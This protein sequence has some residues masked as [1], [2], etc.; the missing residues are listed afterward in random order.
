MRAFTL[1]SLG[2]PPSVRDLPAPTPGDDQVLVRVHASSV[3]PADAAVVAGRLSGMAEHVFPV[4]IGRDFAGTVEQVG[5]AVTRYTGGEYVYG[6]LPLTN[7]A[8]HD[9]AWAELIVTPEDNFI[10]PAPWS[11]DLAAAGAS[12]LAAITA[13]ALVDALELVE[14][15]TVLVVGATGGVGSF[16][17]QLAVHAGATVIAP[18]LAEDSDYLRGLGVHE[19]LDRGGDVPAAVRQ[20]HPEGVEAM[21]DLVSY[22]SDDFDAYA[23]ALK[24]GGRGASPLSAA[25]DGAGRANVMAGAEPGQPRARGSSPRRRH[26]HGAHRAALRPRS[27]RRRAAGPGRLPHPRQARHPD[28][29]SD[30]GALRNGNATGGDPVE[31]PLE[32]LAMRH[33]EPLVLEQRLEQHR[34]AGTM[35]TRIGVTEQGGVGRLAK[36]LELTLGERRRGGSNERDVAPVGV[37]ATGVHGTLLTADRACGPPHDATPVGRHLPEDSVRGAR[38]AGRNAGPTTC[39]RS[40][41]P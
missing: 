34:D 41:R 29:L 24:E 9:G 2:A 18:G 19:V 26:P 17:V 11:I 5:S 35:L 15:D 4:V 37:G 32:R 1:D 12:P 39:R 10:G 40:R 20:A 22:S 30:K 16:A 3:N 13:L 6:F 38:G 36:K 14:G 8:V 28:Q 31:G 21:L 7:P 25:G 27:G 23:A 33:A